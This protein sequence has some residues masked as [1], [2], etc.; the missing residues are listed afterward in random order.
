MTTL[1]VD[2][3]P[4]G[5]EMDVEALHLAG[6]SRSVSGEWKDKEKA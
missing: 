4:R 1:L 2:L 5:E 3:P 6:P